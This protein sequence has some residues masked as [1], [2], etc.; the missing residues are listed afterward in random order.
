MLMWTLVLIFMTGGQV[1]SKV[2]YSKAEL[3]EAQGHE[4]KAQLEKKG[5]EV[6]FA[7]TGKEEE[8]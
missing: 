7:C 2:Q 8:K 3:C 5:F 6:T 4:I 1:E